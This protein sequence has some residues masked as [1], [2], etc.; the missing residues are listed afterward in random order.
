MT[1]PTT[2]QTPQAPTPAVQRP[3]P[4][5][6]MLAMCVECG[7]GIELP[8]PLDQRALSQ[9]LAA[10]GWFISVLQP[11]TQD[12]Q[13]RMVI[14]PLCAACAQQVY[15]P[16]V[17]KMAEQRRQQLLQVMQQQAQQAPQAQP[18]PQSAPAAAPGVPGAPR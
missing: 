6:S 8:L 15:P 12:P 14:G 3:E 4:L 10:V 2:P 5:C 11:P 18:A 7:H 13:A 16:E 17:F 9:M 1:T